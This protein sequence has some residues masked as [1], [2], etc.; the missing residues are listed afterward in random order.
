SLSSIL[1][2]YFFTYSDEAAIYLSKLKQNP[3]NRK[4]RGI[5]DKL[6]ASYSQTWVKQDKNFK[7]FRS[8]LGSS[9]N[10]IPNAVV[11]QDN[12]PVGTNITFDGE[13][14][15][16]Q[17]VTPDLFNLF[18]KENPFKGA[19][20]H[21]CAVVGNG[22]ILAN[23]SC[24]KQIN[25]ATYVIRCN[26]PPVSNGHEKDTGTKTNIVTANPTLL[27]RRSLLGHSCNAI[28]NAVVTQ[29]NSPVGTNI[30]FDGEQTRIQVVTPDLFNLFPKENPFKGAPWHSCAV[31]GNG[32]Q[33]RI[34]VV[35]P[36]LF[37]LFPEENPFK[38]APWHSCAVVGNGGILGNSSCGKQINSATY[39]I[40]CNLPP[41]SNGHEKDTGTKTNIVTA[42]PTLLFR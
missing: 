19:P 28:P 39:V 21:S 32:E 20:W 17:V 12:S 40:R 13:Q 8:L 6:L 35:T 11:T 2:W 1:L 3:V 16:I 25:S 4:E 22:G 26:L 23:S 18:P 27:F 34:Q 9:C 38:G 7:S 42:N 10:A 41:V 31:V 5:I 36:D 37:N 14:T 33:T 15:R 30:T 29:D 24:G